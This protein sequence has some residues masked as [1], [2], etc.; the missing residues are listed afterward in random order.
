MPDV[1]GSPAGVLT[2]YLAAGLTVLIWASYPVATRAAVTAAF[3]PEDLVM[4]RFGI[5]ALLFLPFVLLRLRDIPARAWREGF[6][7][8]LFHGA[9]MA[10]LVI[11]GLQYAPAS[12]AAALGPGVA[13]AWVAVLGYLFFSHRPSSAAMAGAALIAAGVFALTVHSAPQANAGVLLGDAMFLAASALGALYVL[14]LRASGI[15]AFDG[16]AIVSIYSAL[17]V[18]PWYLATVDAPFAHVPARELAFQ[19]LWQ[20]VLIG[21]V[22]M[23]AF[24]HG[25]RRLGSER[26][27]ALIALVPALSTALGAGLLA[28]LPT[29]AEL[30]G[31]AM[32][33]LGVAIAAGGRRVLPAQAGSPA[34]SSASANRAACALSRP[35]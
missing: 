5:G 25:I 16:A 18:V 30:A 2:G 13:C 8:T 4:L 10:G 15:A 32:I 27:S 6:A 14:R 20:G 7:L 34:A 1:R 24:N 19:V 21:F 35:G 12:H 28:E 33:A 11:F 17:I 3:A 31:I 26:A 23:L 29:A 9:G 22:A